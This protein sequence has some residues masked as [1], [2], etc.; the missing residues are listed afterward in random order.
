MGNARVF[1]LLPWVAALAG[2]PADPP[3]EYAF[4]PT[5]GDPEEAIAVHGAPT[6]SEDVAPILAQHCLGC[7]GPDGIAGIPL[8]DG[9]NAAQRAW[10]VKAA[11]TAREMPPFPPDNCGDCNTFAPARW[12]DDEE[13]AVL[14]A[15]A[16]AGAPLG[17]EGASPP[18]PAPL[19]TLGEVDVSL[20]PG[21]DYQPSNPYGEDDFRCFLVDPALDGDAFLV[22]YDVRPGDARIVHH[23]SLYALD[24]ASAEGA[25]E[26]LDLLDAAPG[27]PCLHGPVFP[28]RLVAGWTPG[29]GATTLPDGTGVRL[30][31]GR[32]AVLQVH[33]SMAN[34]SF[35][36]RT[37]VDLDLED[38]VPAEGLM[39]AV[40]A[41]GEAALPPGEVEVAVTH[42][43]EIP[44]G[45]SGLLWGLSPRMHQLGSSVRVEVVRGGEV[46]CAVDVPHWDLHWEDLYLYEEPL[47]VAAGDVIR[48]TCAY[49]TTSRTAPVEWGTDEAAERCMA[50]LYVEEG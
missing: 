2:C 30:P 47:T 25:A 1:A 38:A 10:N 48:L 9:A 37:T 18:E 46:A 49:D 4:P 6:Y 21:A 24:D 50:W 40:E 16:E 31:G 41:A 27:W 15:W 45:V 23:A 5:C 14:A 28:A 8:H 12:L 13:I 33:Y 44:A 19:P 22:G 20:D 26:E 7:H 39:V 3:F 11:V 17:D 32:R 35:P 42:E 29:T 36:D 34:G 43:Q